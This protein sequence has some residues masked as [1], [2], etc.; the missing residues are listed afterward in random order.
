MLAEEMPNATFVKS[1][2]FL[3][4]RT[5]PRRLNNVAT[6]F[7]TECWDADGAQA[8]TRERNSREP[9]EPAIS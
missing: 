1:R 9:I 8:S 5:R 6:R 4:W 2:G 7:V 3:E